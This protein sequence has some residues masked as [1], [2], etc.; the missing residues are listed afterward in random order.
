MTTL[1]P[2]ETHPAGGFPANPLPVHEPRLDVR[3]WRDAVVDRVGVPVHDHYVETFWLPVLGPTATWLLRRLASGLADHPDGYSTD[4]E[5]LARGLGVAYSP[6]RHG[7]FMRAL[8]RCEMFG[9]A[10]RLA[11]SPH[12][13][14]E[15]RT[16]MPPL[17][18][19]HLERLPE[20]LRRAHG[21]RSR[22]S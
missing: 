6:G 20:E 13:T 19:R 17:P 18:R 2:F 12:L 10:R 11:S 15:V 9:A 22:P 16:A 14:L 3:P 21:D 8:H 7:P 4:M 5:L 1:A